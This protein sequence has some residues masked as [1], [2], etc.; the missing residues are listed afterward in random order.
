MLNPEISL[1]VQL[2]PVIFR[3]DALYKS[4]IILSINEIRSF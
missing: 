2:C 3:T 1:I 4:T